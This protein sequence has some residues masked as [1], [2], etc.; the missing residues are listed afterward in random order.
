MTSCPSVPIRPAVRRQDVLFTYSV[1]ILK[2]ASVIDAEKDFASQVI[3]FD[4]KDG[5]PH[6]VF[7]SIIAGI[8]SP[9][10]KSFIH[11]DSAPGK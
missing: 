10:F 3:I 11:S 6:E 2:R 1:A 4:L 7:H 9:F 8:M 5:S